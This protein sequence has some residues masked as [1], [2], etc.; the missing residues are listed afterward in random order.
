MQQSCSAQLPVVNVQVAYP[1]LYI[2]ILLAAGQALA[3]L[4]RRFISLGLNRMWLHSGDTIYR[5]AQSY[6]RKK[7]CGPPGACAQAPGLPWRKAAAKRYHLAS[8]RRQGDPAASLYILISG[9]ARL[10]RQDSLP[11]G[12]ARVEDEVSFMDA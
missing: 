3:P 1:G 11:N 6:N 7:C 9:R 4:I 8:H 10:V 5:F 12:G 2:D